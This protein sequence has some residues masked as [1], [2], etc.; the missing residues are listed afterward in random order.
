MSSR[1]AEFLAQA[2]QAGKWA[3]K[4]DDLELKSCWLAIAEFY[5][6]LARL[7]E[8]KVREAQRRKQVQRRW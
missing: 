8:A 6:D 4:V 5:R 1:K 3:D 7:D 2:E